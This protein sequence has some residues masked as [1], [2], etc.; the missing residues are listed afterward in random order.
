[1]AAAA[2]R[3]GTS[4]LG[5]VM[6]WAGGAIGSLAGGAGAIPGYAAGTA[7]GFGTGALGELV[8]QAIEEGVPLTE[9]PSKI[10][11]YGKEPTRL[12]RAGL[13]GGL[14]I[15]PGKAF[16]VPGKVAQSV[17][18]GGLTAGA[19][20]TARVTLD[21]NE[22]V[23]ENIPR[24]G[25]ATA[26]GAATGGLLGKFIPDAAASVSNVPKKV[27]PPST[28]DDLL[29]HA[30]TD[31]EAF[32]KGLPYVISRGK[33]AS[34]FDELLNRA[35]ALDQT[36]PD[37]AKALRESALA[38]GHLEPTT[39]L[40][41]INR[42]AVQ[43]RMPEA[44]ALAEA[45]VQT[46]IGGSPVANWV[47]GTRRRLAAD[48]AKKA[49]EEQKQKLI[50]EKTA[51]TQKKLSLAQERL[52]KLRAQGATSKEEGTIRVSETD[53]VTGQTI[54]HTEKIKP[55][56]TDDILEGALGGP[57]D[58]GPAAPPPPPPAPPLTKRQTSEVPPTGTRAREIYDAWRVRGRSHKVA[59]HLA[60]QDLHPLKPPSIDQP[61]KRV[62][63]PTKP[64]DEGAAPAAVRPPDDG[65]PPSSGG[66][67]LPVVPST[68]TR[69]L[70]PLTGAAGEVPAGGVAGAVTPP[71]PTPNPLGGLVESYSQGGP[72]GI[73]DALR[74]ARPEAPVT[75]PV[76][77][78]SEVVPSDPDFVNTLKKIVEERSAPA[79]QPDLAA[80]GIT[81]LTNYRVTDKFG[82]VY[83]LD[84]D[85]YA[86]LPEAIRRTV[87]AYNR[88]NLSLVATARELGQPQLSVVTGLDVARS[89]GG[90]KK[91]TAST[92]TVDLGEEAIKN[93]TNVT[94][95]AR[96]VSALEKEATRISRL[97]D[98][99]P[100]PGAQTELGKLLT[101]ANSLTTMARKKLQELEAA[102]PAPPKT[103][104]KPAGSFSGK[105]N[106]T[107]VMTNEEIQEIADSIMNARTGE[108]NA[109]EATQAWREASR[110]YHTSKAQ[111][112]TS[113]PDPRGLV[114]PATGQTAT[115]SMNELGA[116]ISRTMPKALEEAGTIPKGF[117]RKVSEEIKKAVEA[118]ALHR[119]Q[120][121]I[122]KAAP[123]V[124]EIVDDLA[125]GA[126]VLPRYET[127]TPEELQQRIA[128]IKERGSKADQAEIPHIE[129]EL[130][131]RAAAGPEALPAATQTPDV[132]TTPPPVEAAEVLGVSP[133][134]AD[135]LTAYRKGV[136]DGSIN[137]EQAAA[138][139]D[140]LQK[141]LLRSSL[142]KKEDGGFYA[143]SLS[144]EGFSDLAKKYPELA[145]KLLLVAGGGLT[146]AALD[147]FDDP[148]VSGILGASAGFGGAKA[149][150]LLKKSG[151]N[152]AAEPEIAAAMKDKAGLKEIAG[153]AYQLAPH[154]QRTNYLWSMYGLPANAVAG[155]WGAGFFGTLTKHLAGDPR[156]GEA[157]KE[158]MNPVGWFKEWMGA[159]QEAMILVER[160]LAGDPLVRAEVG[161]DVVD[162]ALR[163]R[164]PN[165][166]FRI[167]MQEPAVAMAAGDL[168][169]RRILM[170]N[171]FTEA[172]ARTMTLTNEPA[173]PVL[174]QMMNL[175][176][177]AAGDKI[178][179]PLFDIA[180]PFLRTPLNVL[181]QG[182][183]RLPGIGL[184]LQNSMEKH[185]YKPVTDMKE[186]MWEQAISSSILFGTY[187][188]GMAIPPEQANQYRRFITN[189]GGQYSLV[190]GLGFAM[191]QGSQKRNTGPL[192]SLAT[193]EVI[194][195]VEWAFPLPTTEPIG[196]WIRFLGKVGEGKEVS[197][198]PGAI[199]AIKR[200]LFP[201]QETRK[202][203]KIQ[204]KPRRR[205]E[206][207]R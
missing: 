15:L 197:A 198:P 119:Y 160:A 109:W 84:P 161:G 194:N 10:M 169:T 202:R 48:A 192:G 148:L 147:P 16:M 41:E 33:L 52:E 196:N 69:P 47:A 132:P 134:L 163:G 185:G 91:I 129:R 39:I 38:F 138:M 188:M 171:G 61:V 121:G 174:Q 187:L 28:M 7:A 26:I 150:S 123:P 124:E 19:G 162:R 111:G 44:M 126:G 178:A 180:L 72:K 46:R 87:E 12:G 203:R 195:S 170:R 18:R 92:P 131:G 105:V 32:R 137:P 156:A 200:E 146:G 76:S 165:D 166:P 58:L 8:A 77:A 96:K 189:A 157:V 22:N 50:A 103:P 128:I 60:E 206:E 101:R 108:L 204:V 88:N 89:L 104:D 183:Q 68:L 20:E 199:P 113:V 116:L 66:P 152:L 149:L 173:L 100:D 154:I 82:D 117:G 93:L 184:L 79:P 85:K 54:V 144:P 40:A 42:L 51:L 45:A 186:K 114:D 141:E 106:P 112:L 151:V 191:G 25:A 190:A 164:G 65:N 130:A 29:T 23:P 63:L 35:A 176:R 133:E 73:E 67:A 107:D 158:M 57:S 95:A 201:E 139:E 78:A 4:I 13:E 193:P 168:A 49:A 122:P 125:E 81:N 34:N 53:P 115:I 24:I 94:A 179:G 71:Q 120:E 102:P 80:E 207:R 6:P 11:E 1:M 74:A 86:A 9:I 30:G 14:T 31:V 172:E 70:I 55:A 56:E 3:T 62:D 90:P 110:L 127:F 135:R 182:A 155:P 2:T 136:L 17:I 145:I 43:N 143:G 118:E 5:S 175:K 159:R 167:Y 97:I 59:L 142:P 140:E 21:P 75:P 205:E 83:E 98:S 36:N 64:P 177:R 99:N 37:F 27:P 181:E 153:A